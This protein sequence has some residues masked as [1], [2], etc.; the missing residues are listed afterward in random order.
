MIELVGYM[1]MIITI[2]SFIFKD[3]NKVR[4]TNGLACVIWII[5]GVYKISYPIILVNLIVFF[6]H[7]YWLYKNKK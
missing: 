7:I 3:I 2:I 1:G 6:I 4:I 5:Y